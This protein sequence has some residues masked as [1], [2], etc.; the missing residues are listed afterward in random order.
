M[1]PTLIF[2][3][4]VGGLAAT[5]IL[6]N[7]LSDTL[8]RRAARRRL[9]HLLSL[10]TLSS[11]RA[12]TLPA[13]ESYALLRGVSGA[14]SDAFKLGLLELIAD[15]VLEPAGVG[16]TALR[17]GS[18]PLDP[19]AVSLAAIHRLWDSSGQLTQKVEEIAHRAKQEYG[20]LDGFTRAEV[21]P[22]LV[23]AG[24][25]GEEG[26]RVLGSVVKSTILC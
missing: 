17:R 23:K 5:L 6:F 2:W 7:V 21:L 10:D 15:G 12:W 22:Q 24:L 4:A 16:Q 19:L 11:S 25:Y 14:G 3:I 13:P 9:Q 1:D 8:E 18:A 26:H 20:S